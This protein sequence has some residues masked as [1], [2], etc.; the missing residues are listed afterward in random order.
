ML[1]FRTLIASAAVVLSTA[2]PALAD[3]FLRVNNRSGM[4]IVALWIS[5]SNLDVWDAERLRGN[6]IGNGAAYTARFS[7]VRSCGYDLRVRYA[8]GSEDE[9]YGIN[10]CGGAE[11]TIRP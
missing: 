5:N 11:Y 2:A 6:R 7:N 3:E 4:T 8:N 10:I 1:R 9:F